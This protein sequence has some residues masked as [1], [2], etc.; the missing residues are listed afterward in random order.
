MQHFTLQQ[1]EGRHGLW[2]RRALLA[3]GRSHS[4]HH[5]A[6]A[7]LAPLM[8]TDTSKARLSPKQEDKVTWKQVRNSL[9]EAKS[10]RIRATR[11][12]PPVKP[13]PTRLRAARTLSA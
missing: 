6:G 8:P 4:H 13:F 12:R 1:T 11:T 7:V 9:A 10:R 5:P 2:S 3:V